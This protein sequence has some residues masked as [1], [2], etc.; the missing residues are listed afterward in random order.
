MG[1]SSLIAVVFVLI[2]VMAWGTL[3]SSAAACSACEIQDLVGTAV[4]QQ[5]FYRLVEAI[6]AAGLAE[7]LAAEGP[8][9]LFAPSDAAFAALPVGLWTEL[10]DDPEAL[11][12]L[13]W[14]HVIP[15]RY[16]AA[17]LL[18]RA[19]EDIATLSDQTLR[20]TVDSTEVFV[21]GSTMTATNILAS[22]GLIHEIDQVLIPTE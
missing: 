17:D 14:Y 10:L 22:N 1:K 3:S 2:V 20:I 6:V 21:N 12:A 11:A 15:G 7:E 13:L 4:Q 5:G 18:E 8:F 19:D 9:T 16:S